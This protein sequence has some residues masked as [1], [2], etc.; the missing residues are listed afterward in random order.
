MLR[1]KIAPCVCAIAAL[2]VG[3]TVA[4]AGV[5]FFDILLDGGQEVPAND[6]D[7]FGIA[8]IA[9]D[10]VAKTLDVD[11]FTDGIAFDDL[12]PAGPN[13]TPIHIHLAPPGATGAIVIDLGLHAS[14][15][16]LGDGLL[17]FSAADIPIGGP[18]GAVP[19]SDP[20]TNEQALFDG[21]LYINIHTDRFPGGE[22]RGQIPA[23]GVLPF[24]GLGALLATR[25]RR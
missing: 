11:I 24:C 3:G 14:F 9:F 6:S 19:A 13:G 17:G 2:A 8:T 10:D 5:T 7:A 12:R 1:E 4:N 23:P 20:V 16:D 22:I 21:N 18:Q 25:R 15:F